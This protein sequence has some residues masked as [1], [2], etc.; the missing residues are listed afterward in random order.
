MQLD[1]IN[2]G[3]HRPYRRTRMA[4]V[5]VL[6]AGACTWAA[7]AQGGA[8]SEPGQGSAAAFTAAVIPRAGSLAIGVTFGE[9]LAGHQN[10][11]AKAQSQALDLGAIGTSLTGYNCGSRA[12]RPDQLPE[13]LIVETGEPGASKGVTQTDVGGAFSKFGLATTAPYSQ[14]ITTTAPFGIAGVIDVG[15]GVSKSWSGMVNGQRQAGASTDIASVTLPGGV[16]LS[17]LHWESIYQSTG[18]PQHT[19]TFTIGKATLG[20]AALPTNNPTQTLTQV[21]TVLDLVGLQLKVPTA[22]LTSG[23]LYEDPLQI[24]VVPNSTRDSALNTVL[25]G[26]EPIRQQVFAAALKAFCQSD[27]AITVAD[28]AIAAIS[29]GGSMNISLGGVQASSGTVAGNQYNLGLATPQLGAG[30]LTASPT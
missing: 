7:T 18:S 6:L 16:V 8:A 22:H 1:R 3:R 27:T 13:P 26:I 11:T 20:G 10:G 15:P 25:S 19:A 14:A 21:N 29:G 17:A 24:N 5:G 28:V 23:T 9:A 2:S 12:L 4:A 30:G